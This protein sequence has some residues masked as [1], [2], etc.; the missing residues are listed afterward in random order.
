M[1]RRVSV[2]NSLPFQVG[3]QG[4]TV[5]GPFSRG[6][7]AQAGHI[8]DS[9][10]IICM[11]RGHAFCVLACV[12]NLKTRARSLCLFLRLCLRLRHLYHVHMMRVYIGS[13]AH[14]YVF[15]LV[16]FHGHILN[17]CVHALTHNLHARTQTHAHT[18]ARTQ[19]REGTC[20]HRH[21]CSHVSPCSSSRQAFS[22]MICSM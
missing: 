7:P 12:F 4:K 5:I 6:K 2:R 17:D 10:S 19:A 13:C 9:I 8:Y 15:M 14:I 22:P 11:Q 1:R 21:E 16:N 20:R 18:H 3:E